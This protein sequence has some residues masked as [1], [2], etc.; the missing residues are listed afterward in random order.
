[1]V[2][3]AA[4]AEREGLLL[5][6]RA[7]LLLLRRL[8]EAAG[9]RLLLLAGDRCLGRERETTPGEPALLW[10]RSFSLPVDLDP[11]ARFFAGRGGELPVPAVRRSLL[12]VFAGL[13]GAGDFP[14]TREA[15]EAHVVNGGPDALLDIRTLVRSA[16]PESVEL[17]PL[18]SWLRFSH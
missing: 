6:P 12:T 8:A 11:F 15:F 2:L 10:H 1:G 17:R 13:L 14:R 18:T 3:A 5:F 4:A 16:N 7:G 9:G